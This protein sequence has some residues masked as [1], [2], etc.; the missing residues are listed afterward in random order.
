[1][2]IISFIFLIF[3]LIVLVQVGLPLANFKIWENSFLK[4]SSPLTSPEQVQENVLGVSI[5]NDNN[6]PAFISTWQRDSKTS[7]DHFY[8]SI[9]SINLDK[10]EV[11]ID[12][13]DLSRGLAHLPGSA[14]P[15]EK[16]NVFISGHSAL[17]LIFNQN[18]TTVF[19]DLLKVKQKDIIKV[20]IGGTEF[21]YEVI[22]IKIVDPKDL[23][24]IYPKD[25]T[26]RYITLMTCVPPGLNTKRLVVLGELK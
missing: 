7:Y 22:N 4:Q 17:P 19:S 9:P 2:K 10:A 24:V 21:S 16:G 15:G 25:A 11:F 26:G 18:T 12:S 20:N 14:L 6:F 5:E 23:S 3:G 1:M 8:V 13:N